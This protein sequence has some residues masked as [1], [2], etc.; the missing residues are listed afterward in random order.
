MEGEKRAT[1]RERIGEIRSSDIGFVVP[2]ATLPQ[3]AM[4]GDP[5][6]RVDGFL[7]VSFVAGGCVEIAERNDVPTVFA[8]ID[9]LIDSRHA[10]FA[11]LRIIQ[12]KVFGA[13][14]AG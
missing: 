2:E 7:E 3:A 11:S 8:R 6:R 1:H 5:S 9:M 12:R 13:V 4:L 10:T 14:F